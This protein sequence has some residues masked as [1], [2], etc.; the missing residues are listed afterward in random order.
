H[1]GATPRVSSFHAHSQPSRLTAIVQSLEAGHDVALLTDAGTPAVSD[2]GGNLVQAAREAGAPVVVVPGPSAVVAALSVSGL[3]ADR[4]TFLGFPPR[5]GK[6]R[7]ELLEH[8]ASSRWTT[9][10]FE[11]PTRLVALLRDLEKVC[12]DARGA[13]VARELTKVHEEVRTGTLAQLRG[14]Y[15]ENPPRGEVTLVV[16]ARPVRAARPAVDEAEVRA[17]AQA[18]LDEGL[19]RRD[20]AAQVAKELSMARREAYRIVTEL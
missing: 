4:F 7:R 15:E 19:S 17:R 10:F 18:L 6:D 2:P 9:V 14:Y 20:A 1:A 5:K 13:A 8:A 3:P 12:G 16:G 11:A